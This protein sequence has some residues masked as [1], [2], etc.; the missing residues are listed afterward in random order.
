MPVQLWRNM[1]SLA[2]K[3]HAL[4]AGVH[5]SG[6]CVR[7]SVEPGLPGTVCSPAASVRLLF[8]AGAQGMQQFAISICCH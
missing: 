7:S 1:A 4:Q 8:A 5:T 2:L 6:C 3:H